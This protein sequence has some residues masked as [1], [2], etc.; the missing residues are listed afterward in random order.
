M[1]QEDRELDAEERDWLSL[2]MSRI[3]GLESPHGDGRE[4]RGRMIGEQ[5]FRLLLDDCLDGS[6]RG[7]RDAAWISLGYHAGLRRGEIS[8][9]M[10][11]DLTC[12]NDGYLL[13]IHGKGRRGGKKF[14]RIV[15]SG[16]AQSL[17]RDWL[18]VRGDDAGYVFTT[19]WCGGHSRDERLTG[20]TMNHILKRRLRRLGLKK[21]STHD[22]RRSFI[23][24]AL[25]NTD[26]SLVSKMVGHSSVHMTANRSPTTGDGARR[27]GTPTGLRAMVR[28]FLSWP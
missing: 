25:Q 6:T 7:V 17:L 13:A 18:A 11:S 5:E 15:V 19:L 24:R 14:R 21:A 28:A 10:M 22:L 2:Q 8:R 16:T 12:T 20:P 9:L 4:P 3:R 26:I 23:S 27:N 1:A